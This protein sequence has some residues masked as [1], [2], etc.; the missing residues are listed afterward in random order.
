[1]SLQITIKAINDSAGPD[2]IIPIFLIFSTYPRMIENSALSPII[3]K[4]AKTIRKTTKEVQCFYAKR[5]VIDA[6]VMRNGPNIII[7]LELPIQSDVRV[8]RET[9]R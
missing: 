2:R 9:N 7:T 5:Q 1:M 4:R 8:W 6:F 3:I